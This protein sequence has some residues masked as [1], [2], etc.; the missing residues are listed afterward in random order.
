MITW[1]DDPMKYTYLRKLERV[2]I[3]TKKKLWKFLSWW[4]R[5]IG[6]IVG[7]ECTKV[8]EKNFP[9]AIRRLHDLL[10]KVPRSRSCT[11]G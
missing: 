6:K 3:E 10:P 8:H 11:R 1:L 2:Y 9:V 5:G 7:Y 4:Y